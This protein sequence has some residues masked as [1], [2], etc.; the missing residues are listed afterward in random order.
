MSTAKHTQDG[1][2]VDA[3]LTGPNPTITGGPLRLVKCE[4]VVIA[5]MPAWLDDEREEAHANAK[6]VAAA[7][8]MLA[9][10]LGVVRVADRATVEFDA[11]RA[12]IAKAAGERT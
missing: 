2:W 5:F 6:L 12:A 4:G 7:P 3:G 10:L 8:D 1:P 9:A 11:A